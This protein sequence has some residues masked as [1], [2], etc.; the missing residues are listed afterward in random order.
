MKESKCVKS[1]RVP[2]PVTPLWK[3]NS[4]AKYKFYLK[5]KRRLSEFSNSS[6]AGFQSHAASNMK[7]NKPH[8]V[9]NV[10]TAGLVGQPIVDESTPQ[11]RTVI[12]EIVR[13]TKEENELSREV[14]QLHEMNTSLLWLLKKAT[15]YETFRNHNFES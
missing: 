8:N 13:L 7:F 9:T 15:M 11:L 3:V 6:L 12:T 5:N 2:I 14:Q 4:I 1:F 10:A